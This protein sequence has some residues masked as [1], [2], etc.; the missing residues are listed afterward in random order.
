[1]GKFSPLSITYT[2]KH[3]GAVTDTAM[4]V[5]PMF[6]TK[7]Q[8]MTVLVSPSFLAEILAPYTFKAEKTSNKD[9]SI[10]LTIKPFKVT[11]NGHTEV[12]AK[13]ALAADLL[14][15]CQCFYSRYKYTEGIN[16]KQKLFV[17][18]VIK[19]LCIG[20]KEDLADNIIIK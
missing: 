1:M 2:R 4:F 3:W 7:D 17:P 19:A 13:K 5:K 16:P 8:H 20:N 18:Y 6:V 10:S 14:D 12:L 9:G 15:Y 11:G